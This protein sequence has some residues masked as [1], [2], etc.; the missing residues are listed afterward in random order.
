MLTNRFLR[1][2]DYTLI[3]STLIL[4]A[5]SLVM[6]SSATHVNTMGEDRYW[7]LQRQGLFALLNIL[8]LIVSLN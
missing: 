8:V 3:G 1:S 2:L 5:V 7:Y 4:L 6:I